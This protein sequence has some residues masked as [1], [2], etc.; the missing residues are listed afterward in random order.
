MD[1]ALRTIIDGEAEISAGAVRM[2]LRSAAPVSSPMAVEVAEIP[3][4]SYDE[5]LGGWLE[6]G[7]GRLE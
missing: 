6:V 2:L 5:L 3:L 1:D 7:H 4:Q